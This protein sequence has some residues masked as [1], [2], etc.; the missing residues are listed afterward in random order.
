M[1]NFE[2]LCHSTFQPAVPPGAACQPSGLDLACEP[3]LAKVRVN[4]GGDRCMGAIRFG[5]YH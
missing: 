5:K 2:R 4:K 1:Y 3:A